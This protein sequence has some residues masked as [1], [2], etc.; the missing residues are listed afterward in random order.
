VIASQGSPCSSAPLPGGTYY[1]NAAFGDGTDLGNGNFVVYNGNGNQVTVSALAPG[2]TYYFSAFEYS[3]SGASV[4]YSSVPSSTSRTTANFTININGLQPSICLG[5]TLNLQASGA[6]SYFWSPSTDLSSSTGTNVL[7]FPQSSESFTVT[8]TTSAGCPA[9]NSFTINV[10]PLPVTHFADLNDLCANETPVLLNSGTPAGGA[11]SGPGV[12]GGQF[13][14]SIPGAG[15]YT[16]YYS[17]TDSNGCTDVNTASVHVSSLPNVS[18]SAI[19]PSCPYDGPITLHGSPSGGNYFG[20][21][22][23]SNKFRP[24]TVGSGIYVVYYTYEGSNGCSDTVNQIAV[25]NALPAVNLGA[26][27]TI[28]AG[29]SLLL[30]P[31]S[32]SSYDWSTG[33]TA[34]AIT[35]DSSGTGIGVAAFSVEVTNT[36]GC[37]NS[38]TIDIAFDICNGVEALAN[39]T[40][41]LVFPN[42]FQ[43]TMTVTADQAFTYFIYDIYGTLLEKGED[44]DHRITTGDKLSTGV[45]LIDIDTKKERHSFAIVKSE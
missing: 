10:N 31:G 34:S 1:A 23:S 4:S 40:E 30:N 32:F 12:I 45:Y 38:D 6:T 5:D 13:D 35:D 39:A 19:N 16:L 14:P 27:T 25:V 21:G 42:P 28:C 17:Y 43:T 24:A 33:S 11:Y 37:I 22:V 18:L 2:M 44:S 8:A 26:D 36:G 9:V 20:T 29:N 15:T 7:A 3:G 41:I